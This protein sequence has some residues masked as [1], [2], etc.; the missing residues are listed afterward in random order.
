MVVGVA[1][2]RKTAHFIDPAFSS[3]ANTTYHL[4]IQLGHHGLS[5]C[6]LNKDNNQ[7]VA[8]EN[9][10]FERVN[11]DQELIGLLPEVISQSAFLKEEY[12]SS[13]LAWV[14]AYSTLIPAA[15]YEE[16]KKNDYL[17]FNFNDLKTTEVGSDRLF[18]SNFHNIYYRPEA[19][20]QA[21]LQYY[22]NIQVL[23]Y[24]T[25]LIE[26]ILRKSK[27]HDDPITHLNVSNGRFELIIAQQQALHYY[28]SFEYQTSEDLAYYLLYV[29]EQLQITPKQLSLTLTG[30]IDQNSDPYALITK[31]VGKVDFETRNNNFSYTSAMNDMPFHTYYSLLNQLL[32]AS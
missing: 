12:A 15:L 14:G 6:A 13:S 24:G 16:R 8:L 28:N 21:I 10:L 20:I 29:C 27:F 31:Y 4:S 11:T 17:N 19:V 1:S 3:K 22:P 9:F 23:H 25:T 26:A 5:C 30:E 32:C 2:S 7:Y 18:S